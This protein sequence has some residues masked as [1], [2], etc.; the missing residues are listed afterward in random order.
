MVGA[1]RPSANTAIPFL[2]VLSCT[3]GHGIQ[4][5][6]GDAGTEDGAQA[7]LPDA[8]NDLPFYADAAPET[9][10]ATPDVAGFLCGNGVLDDH[11]QCDDGNTVSGDGCSSLCQF[12]VV[13]ICGDKKLNGDE[14]CDDGN[15][16]SGDGCS[17]DCRAV[18]PGWRC[19]SVGRPCAPICGDRILEGT[20]TCDDGN[21]IGGDGCSSFCLTEP[22]WDC[23]SGT[24]VWV[25]SI[26]GGVDLGDGLLRCGDGIMSGAEECDYGPL[27]ND[28]EYGGC[29]TSCMLGPRCGDGVLNGPEECDL[30]DQNGQIY[31]KGRCL[32]GCTKS[33]Y[34]GDGIVDTNLGE[35]C[36]IGDLNGVT[37]DNSHWP[38]TADPNGTVLCDPHCKIRLTP[39]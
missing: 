28:S 11:E 29:A 26:D 9:A 21:T 30:G 19:R 39:P 38:P 33:H 2:L 23:A 4:T 18:E 7:S 32:I 34:C 25:S 3:T 37:V 31:G 27:N 35:E 10:A 20:E 5:R 16:V 14:V 6:L 36:D 15:S 12:E 24:C 17:A 22:G 13:V 1:L 8:R